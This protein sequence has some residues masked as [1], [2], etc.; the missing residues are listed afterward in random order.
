MIPLGL[1]LFQFADR[2][3]IRLWPLSSQLVHT[4]LV[5]NHW[6][7]WS[8]S[9]HH[10]TDHSTK[11]MS[12]HN[13]EK[14]PMLEPV[15]NYWWKVICECLVTVMLLQLRCAT[16]NMTLTTMPATHCDWAEKTY[17]S[18]DVL[19]Y[20]CAYACIETGFM[21]VRIY[22]FT[23]YFPSIIT[24]TLVGK[25]L[26]RYT[27]A[28]VH[29]ALSNHT[30]MLPCQ[31]SKPQHSLFSLHWL[32]I[33]VTSWYDFNAAV[34]VHLELILLNIIQHCMV[35]CLLK[36]ASRGYSSLALVGMCHHRNWK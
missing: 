3:H 18:R 12:Y 2:V 28:T 7:K 33:V 25:L 15:S 26:V 4:F 16:K 19:V 14:V 30:S 17:S 13:S 5:M 34:N 10:S 6:S 9:H 32:Q 20:L 31:K 1:P 35:A 27:L 36:H 8:W 11:S 29:H 24:C 21:P 22:A 23:N